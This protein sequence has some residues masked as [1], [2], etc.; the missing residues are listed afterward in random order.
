MPYLPDACIF[1]QYVVENELLQS[2]FFSDV[3]IDR[4]G[5]IAKPA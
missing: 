5:S 2:S 1:C 4:D 3:G